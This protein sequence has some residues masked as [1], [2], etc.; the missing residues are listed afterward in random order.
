M[1][2]QYAPSGLPLDALDERRPRTTAH[3]ARAR[4]EDHVTTVDISFPLTGDRVPRDHG[5]ALYGALSRAVPALHGASWLAVHP[6]GGKLVDKSTL[7]LS[8]AAR[9][10]LRMPVERIGEVMPLVGASLEVNG[11]AIRLG[12]PSVHP[13]APSASLDSRLVIVK[14][15]AVPTRDHPELARRS[16]DRPAMNSRVER[17][18]T[19]QLEK[20]NIAIRPE[21]RGHGRMIVGGRSV[22]GYSVRVQGLDADASLRLQEHGL[23]GKRRMGCGVFRP[24]RGA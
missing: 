1:S 15:T 14:L 12:A 8:K 5:Y 20:L 23:G 22:I 13:L 18:L 4:K 9:L 17:E 19:R 11:A 6:L 7:A 10:R 21:L 3:A 2:A 16:L 24:T